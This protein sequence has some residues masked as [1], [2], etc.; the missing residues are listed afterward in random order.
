MSAKKDIA[1]LVR[2][3]ALKAWM[4][5]NGV[6]RMRLDGLELELGPEPPPPGTRTH[7]TPPTD[8]ERAEAETARVNRILFAASS[9]RPRTIGQQ[10]HEKL[11]R[12]KAMRS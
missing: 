6:R 2:L 4:R 5:D 1:D 3:D 9:V 12:T 7:R 11:Q 10:L 8:E